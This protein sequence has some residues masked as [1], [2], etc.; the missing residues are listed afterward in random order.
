MQSGRWE[1][2]RKSQ[3]LNTKQTN[4]WTR[5]DGKMNEKRVSK[6]RDRMI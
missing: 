6:E 5:I 4:G 3:N 2:E 1:E